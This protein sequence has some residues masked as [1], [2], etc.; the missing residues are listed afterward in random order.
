MAL[1]S[2][3][4]T[5]HVSGLA[6]VLAAALVH[7]EEQ[8][9]RPFALELIDGSRLMCAIKAKKLP[10][11]TEYALVQL[12]MEKVNLIELDHAVS[13]AVVQMKNG[14]RIRGILGPDSHEI[15]TAI[16]PLSIEWAK[17]RGL[18]SAQHI[19]KKKIQDSPRLRKSCINKLRQI[20]AGKEQWAMANN[21]RDSDVK[22]VE[23]YIKGNR[24]PTCPA[25]GKYTY[26][27]VG[28]NATCTV[29]GH[30][31]P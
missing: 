2:R 31:L 9:T 19:E 25:G 22:G 17:V 21:R 29:P 13:N 16:G 28:N 15:E 8:T 30:A 26:N 11:K 4:R 27:V 12:P 1:S 14:D 3:M 5:H 23:T 18:E 24:M 20:E 6:L 10:L 7:G